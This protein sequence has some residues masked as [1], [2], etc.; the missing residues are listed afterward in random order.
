MLKLR[1][2]RKLSYFWVSSKY[3][4]WARKLFLFFRFKRQDF[5]TS[6]SSFFFRTFVFVMKAEYQTLPNQKWLRVS[7]TRYSEK[8]S[9]AMPN[10]DNFVHNKRRK[11]GDKIKAINFT[12]MWG[13]KFF[14]RKITYGRERV[15]LYEDINYLKFLK[16]IDTRNDC[17]TGE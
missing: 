7:I 15:D 17:Y 6:S 1:E 14:S 8:R 12:V 16:I 9:T 13:I 2:L 4:P 11:K 5:Q 10:R 3:L